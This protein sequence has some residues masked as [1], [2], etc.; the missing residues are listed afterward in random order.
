[1][2]DFAGWE[3]P[4]YY[5]GINEE[6]IHTRTKMSVFDVSHMGRLR[7]EG[8]DAI[9]L[10]QLIC[11]RNLDGTQVGQSKYTHI[12]NERGGVIDDVIVSRHEDHWMMVCNASNRARVTGWL[13]Q[14]AAGRNVTVVDETI[15]TAMLAIQG[16]EAL[17]FVEATF[18]V[19]LQDLKRYWFIDGGFM[20]L[21]YS[22]F[23]SGYT[24]EDGVEAVIP[25]GAVG[26]LL[27]LLVG[28]GPEA[29]GACQ[30]AG[31]GA[32]DTLRTEAGMPLY[33]HELRDDIDSLTAGQAWC[34]DLNKDFIGADAMRKIKADG[35]K[36]K[37]A[38][39]EL[40]GKR[41]ARKGYRV[42][43]D[44]KDVGEITSGT[45]SPTLGKSIAM[46]FLDIGLSE[47]GTEVSID[48]GRQENPA[49]VVPLPFY[50]RLKERSAGASGSLVN[51]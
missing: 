2:I 10:L 31:L 24:G 46:G 44:G 6:H 32:R 21:K 19:K 27:P 11:T 8:D 12:C 48:L 3:M 34:V 45:M 49:R 47:P 30:P 42:L 38:G 28:S 25:A 9:P 20:G 41:I 13:T 7:I 40:V 16:P 39:F 36:R 17:A 35:L 14:H 22:I 29:G 15:D 4:V 51:R 37:I 33:G 43:K 26:L 50:K 23:R 1:M 5:T 18:K